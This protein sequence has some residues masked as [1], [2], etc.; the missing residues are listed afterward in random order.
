[1]PKKI[2]ATQSGAG[3]KMKEAMDAVPKTDT[4]INVED[5]PFLK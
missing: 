5:I 4:E 1:M 3:D 2:G